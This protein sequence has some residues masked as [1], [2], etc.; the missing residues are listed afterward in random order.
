[1]QWGIFGGMEMSLE[2]GE[3]LLRKRSKEENV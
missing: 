1:M 3:G 2:A